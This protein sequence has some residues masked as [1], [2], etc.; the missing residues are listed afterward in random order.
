MFKTK[1]SLQSDFSMA[2]LIMKFF[3]GLGWLATG[4]LVRPAV[5]MDVR[6]GVSFRFGLMLF[7]SR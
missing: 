3:T 6:G 7:F 2:I 1:Q 5:S 4:M